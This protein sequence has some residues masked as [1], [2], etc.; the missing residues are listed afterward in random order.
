MVDKI[1]AVLCSPKQKPH[2]TQKYN[3]E[4]NSV[5]GRGGVK[6][7]QIHL[8][9]NDSCFPPTEATL[10]RQHYRRVGLGG[11]VLRLHCRRSP[12]M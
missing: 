5:W 1:L 10:H 7:L 8:Q 6:R 2:H 4:C 12:L 9:Y 11:V 3:I